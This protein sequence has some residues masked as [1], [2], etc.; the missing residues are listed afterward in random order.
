MPIGTVPAVNTQQR[1]QSA[2][3]DPNAFGAGV[4][5]ALSTLGNTLGVEA[6]RLSELQKRRNDS[7]RNFNT[8]AEFIRYQGEQSRRQAERLREA[9]QT[10][11][12]LDLTN[13]VE[14]EIAESNS[15]FLDS[16]PEE[17]RPRYS[18]QLET[19]RQNQVS[20][21]FAFEFEQGNEA[22]RAVSTEIFD[23][24]SASLESGDLDPE[25]AL[26]QFTTLLDQ[27]DLPLL[28]REGLLRSANTRFRSIQFGQL[29]QTAR[30]GRSPVGPADGSEPV[31]PGLLPHERGFLNATSRRESGD[32]YNV[33]YNGHNQEA[34]TFDNFDDHPR[35]FVQRPDGRWS[36]AA[37]RYQFT[38]QE[39]DRV[40]GILG[41]PDFSPVSQDRA[42]L[43][44]AKERYNAQRPD[45]MDFDEALQSGNAEVISNVKT[46]LAGTWEAFETMGD[47]EFV[48]LVTGQSG[49]AGGGTGSAAFP[50]VWRDERFANLPYETRAELAALSA[51][52]T[53]AESV[54]RQRLAEEQRQSA[55][56]Q[57]NL[58]ALNGEI[59]RAQLPALIESGAFRT[60]EEQQTFE[61]YADRYARDRGAA[62][63]IAGQ[64]ASPDY[65]FTSADQKNLNAYIGASGLQS[66]A[67][68]D[69]AY[70][71]SVFNPLVNRTG[72]IPSRAGEVLNDLVLG[73]DPQRAQFALSTLADL[74]AAT[75]GL[76]QRG[77][78]LSTEARKRVNQYSALRGF[79]TP[80]ESWN[81]LSELADPNRAQARQ[82]LRDLGEESFS[83]EDYTV[84]RITD[85][86]DPGIFTRGPSAPATSFQ[87]SALFTDAKA[88]YLEGFTLGQGD[89]VARDYMV[90]Q[91]GAQWGYSDLGGTRRLVKNGVEKFY[92]PVE[93][94][95]TYVDEIVREDLELDAR[96]N[97]S[98]IADP[99]T[100]GEAAAFHNGQGEHNGS[101]LVAIEQPDGNF[102]LQYDEAGAPVRLAFTLTERQ[103]E[104]ISLRAER[105]NIEARINAEE[106]NLPF[107]GRA[108]P[109]RSPESAARLED[110]QRQLDAID[111]NLELAAPEYEMGTRVQQERRL[112][113]F[114]DEA[115]RLR[116]EI[117]NSSSL[118]R[119]VLEQQLE[120]ITA[121]INETRSRLEND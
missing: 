81:R 80:A 121:K 29:V 102:A 74:E 52:Q 82:T 28:E 97:Y 23:D 13:R 27:S 38:A 50:D 99:N 105:A 104:A 17:L 73:A 66:L 107:A 26:E 63:T 8:E 110:L 88:L 98:L 16:V 90:K 117:S 20:G 69:A 5:Q 62:Q 116:T 32:K 19:L 61:Q 42:A 33:R 83:D 87:Q 115:A 55:L 1:T 54:E 2:Q 39:W 10:G 48:E 106:A 7:T 64:L 46:T 103:Q 3:V 4:G 18:V 36:S 94:D 108:Q 57:L 11:E 51:K 114:E 44:L 45:G 85:L 72:V 77:G 56:N 30:E 84:E 76:T 118:D 37:G 25:V 112:Q 58:Q 24:L 41:L 86:L 65:Q 40:S 9:Q 60:A 101:Y 91:L 75:P 96:A 15:A 95:Y 68:G 92:P 109:E 89:A 49:I 43:Y 79:L 31:A 120:S 53:D 78:G 67:E 35:V 71:N 119:R 111:G 34:A 59:G 22:F 93:G 47:E 70:V 12:Y 14:S 100:L 21:A 113:R 6:S